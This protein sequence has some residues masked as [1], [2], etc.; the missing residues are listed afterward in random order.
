M[1]R[2]IAVLAVAGALGIGMN[3]GCAFVFHPF[4]YAPQSTDYFTTPKTVAAARAIRR[5]DARSLERMIAG[6]LDVN[7]R[8]RGG[9][10]LL[11]WSVVHFCLECL[12]TLLECGADIARPQVG[13]VHGRA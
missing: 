13:G 5:G 3:A 10:D 2:T 1:R 9:A 4:Q 12:E 6:G 7:A 8:G 11:K